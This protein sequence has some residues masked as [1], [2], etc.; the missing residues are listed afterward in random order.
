MVWKEGIGL[1]TGIV[2]LAGI[3][4]AIANGDK[5]A[6]VM[7]AFGNSFGGLVKAATGR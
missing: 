6:Q 3:T 1:L 4:F 5:T 7:T 2:V